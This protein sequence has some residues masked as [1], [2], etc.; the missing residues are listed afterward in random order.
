[1]AEKQE[2]NPG[3]ALGDF[4][5]EFKKAPPA[6]KIAIVGVVV[7]VIAIAIYV[8][9]KN[10]SSST[11]VTAATPASGSGGG[12]GG[13]SDANGSPT[14]PPVPTV[15]Q[16]PAPPSKPKP[17][18]QGGGKPPTK[19]L[20]P[21]PAPKP[22]TRVPVGRPSAPKPVVPR[23][24]Q[25]SYGN[26]KKP[27]NTGGST[28]Y[29]GPSPVTVNAARLRPILARQ[30][31]AFPTNGLGTQATKQQIQRDTQYTQTYTHYTGPSPVTVNARRITQ[32]QQYNRSLNSGNPGGFYP[33]E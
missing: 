3:S 14:A 22:P 30:A 1:M 27:A 2:F 12:G 25:A 9:K 7:V 10:A 4:V 20:P 16:P 26:T 18:T 5:E 29:R 17:P 24:P 8:R 19:P 13:A 6:G 21:Q 33:G 23:S 31:G 28:P 15:P 32:M 11:P